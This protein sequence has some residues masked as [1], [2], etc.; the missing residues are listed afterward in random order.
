MGPVAP[1]LYSKTKQTLGI[2]PA[3]QRPVQMAEKPS[4]LHALL[5]GQTFLKSVILIPAFCRKN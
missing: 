4:K 2:A 5:E 1:T 3:V